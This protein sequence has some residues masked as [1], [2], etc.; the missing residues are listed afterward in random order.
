[1]R[2][3]AH[4]SLPGPSPL[5]LSMSPAR[6]A[7]QSAGRHRGAAA[8]PEGKLGPPLPAPARDDLHICTQPSHAP[9]RSEV[10]LSS[11]AAAN[12]GLT[13]G[14]GLGGGS[15][16]LRWMTQPPHDHVFCEETRI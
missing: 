10:A 11:T 13:C 6:P 16:W 8:T 2:A 1:H 9:G 7:G 4:A 3:R 15:A 12:Q 14:G 5:T